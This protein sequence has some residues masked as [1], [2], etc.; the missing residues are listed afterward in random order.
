MILPRMKRVNVVAVGNAE[1]FI[2]A[3]LRRQKLRL[4]SEV[5]LAE[6]AR[7]VARGLQDFGDGDFIGVQSLPV[8]GEKHSEIGPRR[9]IDPLGIAPGHQSGAR[10]RANRSGHVEARQP[11]TFRR[12]LIDA[13]RADVFAAEA[14]EIAVALVVGEDDDE[15]GFLSGSE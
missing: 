3:L 9:H 2:E 1:E 11:G 6:H 14:T 5:P 10:W 15:V 13:R 8:S 12:H 4:I 7:F